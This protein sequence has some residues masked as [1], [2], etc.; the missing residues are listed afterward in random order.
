M[1]RITPSSPPRLAWYQLLAESRSANH[2]ERSRLAK[3][4]R[5]ASRQVQAA[6]RKDPKDA[7]LLR[8]LLKLH[9][10]GDE[11]LLRSRRTI[12]MARRL[13]TLRPN[14]ARDLLLVS[15]V[16]TLVG[17]LS[18]EAGIWRE[19]VRASRLAHTHLGTRASAGLT[20]PRPAAT[21]GRRRLGSGAA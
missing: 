13:L 5:Q 9:L 21:T 4:L 6:L 2:L 11:S 16:M 14:S 7:N 15:E 18:N 10:S 20:H 17:L 8:L 3:R 12:E 19:G 1:S